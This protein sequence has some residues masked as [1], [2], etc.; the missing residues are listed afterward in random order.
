MFLLISFV[1]LKILLY[2]CLREGYCHL[3]PLGTLA[4]YFALEKWSPATLVLW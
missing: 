1:T 3:W 4:C 2:S